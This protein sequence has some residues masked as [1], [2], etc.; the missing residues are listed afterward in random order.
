MFNT[1]YQWFKVLSRHWFCPQVAPKC[2][3]SVLWP[4]PLSALVSRINYACLL[5]WNHLKSHI[6]VF[7]RW[8]RT[9]SMWPWW[10]IACSCGSLWSCASWAPWA[11]FSSPSSRI[12]SLPFSSPAQIC[13][14]YDQRDWVGEMNGVARGRQDASRPFQ[15][16]TPRRF[17]K[18]SWGGL[19][20]D[21][22][23]QL[24][25]EYTCGCVDRSEE[26][27]LLS[28]VRPLCLL[29]TW[30]VFNVWIIKVNECP[31]SVCHKLP[32][33]PCFKIEAR[34]SAYLIYLLW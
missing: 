18:Y 25:A 27:S 30:R 13:L 22:E 34:Q 8:L 23:R 19:K 10:W 31:L 4:N 7:F 9:G 26:T 2:H 16:R 20:P 15:S 6:C 29:E 33:R 17:R 1:V 28:D 24:W 21:E 32:E 3:C 14:V 12:P 5:W 11:Y